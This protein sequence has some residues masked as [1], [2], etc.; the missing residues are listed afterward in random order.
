MAWN[1]FSP[2]FLVSAL[3]HAIVVC[4]LVIAARSPSADSAATHKR[5]ARTETRFAWIATPDA[6]QDPT[7]GGSGGENSPGPI[8]LI[9]RQGAD[10]HSVPPPPAGM[11]LVRRE[12]TE[13]VQT[14]DAPL[15]PMASGVA[16]LPGALDAEPLPTASQ[17]LGRDGGV[18]SRKGGGIGDGDGP[19]LGF[20]EDGNTGG[21]RRV[22]SG[23]ASQPVLVYSVQP[24]YTEEAMRARLQGVVELDA[25]VLP[26]GRLG[27]IRVAR[28][29]DRAFGLDDRAVEAVKQ[30]RF[31][32]GRVGGVAVA[33]PIRVELTFTI[34]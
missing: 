31:L 30:W 24:R 14:L 6:P 29:L 21:G 22:G 32:P 1:R 4:A 10:A 33:V 12:V 2:A 15:V 20:G 28:S 17:G 27:D 7:G 13:V 5:D 19:G 25:V 11:Q 9:E 16:E 8:R 23:G 34:R 18:G 3:S 26:D